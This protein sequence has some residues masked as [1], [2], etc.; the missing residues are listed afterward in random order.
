VLFRW[1]LALLPVHIV[2]LELIIDPA[3]SIVFEAEPAEDDVMRRPPRDPGQRLFGMRTL[4]VAL[5]QGVAVLALVSASYAFTLNRGLPE[6]EARAFA[7]TTLIVAN[8]GLI[9]ANRSWTQTIFGRLKVPNRALWLVTGGALSFLGLVLYVP[10]LQQLFMFSNLSAMDLAIAMALGIAS[11]AW[12][13][14]LKL[15]SRPPL[16]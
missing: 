16:A 6:D 4:A 10:W 2:F 9:F 12:F 7:F 13:E 15:A 1:P 14:V 3:C 5:G 11:I 8:L